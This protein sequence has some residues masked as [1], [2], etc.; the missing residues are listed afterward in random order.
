MKKRTPYFSPT[1][2]PQPIFVVIT[3]VS[4]PIGTTG[5]DDFSLETLELD[6]VFE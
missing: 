1:L 2:E 6:E 4:L 5:V 3:G